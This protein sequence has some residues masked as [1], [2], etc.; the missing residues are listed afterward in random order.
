MEDESGPRN[1]D[2]GQEVERAVLPH[3]VAAR[4]ELHLAPRRHV[5]RE[6]LAQMQPGAE[7]IERFGPETEPV[8][9]GVTALTTADA[10]TPAPKT[11]AAT[12][13]S[14]TGGRRRARGSP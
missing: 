12:S 8:A 11:A 7:A 5:D 10:T 1:L 4:Y 2:R 3:D 9:G 13:L 6:P 14:R